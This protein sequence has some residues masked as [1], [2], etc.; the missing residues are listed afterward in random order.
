MFDLLKSLQGGAGLNYRREVVDAG[1]AGAMRAP[2]RSDVEA[3]AATAFHALPK[4][5]RRAFA[6]LAI[7]VVDD[8]DYDTLADFDAEAAY[9]L[10]GRLDFAA[11]DGVGG[12]RLVIYRR[13]LLDFWVESGAPLVEVVA[14][15]MES[16]LD[17]PRLAN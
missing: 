2:S 10:L 5:A 1:R 6:G 15:I 17:A 8:P 9:E 7:Q 16:E 3:V 14:R 11:R 4:S 13:P 12:P